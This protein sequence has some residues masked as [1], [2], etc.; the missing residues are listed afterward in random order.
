MVEFNTHGGAGQQYQE[1]KV[2][3]GLHYKCSS[4]VVC[5]AM[6]GAESGTPYFTCSLDYSNNLWP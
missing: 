6:M 4:S 3:L 5:W 2:S 1:H